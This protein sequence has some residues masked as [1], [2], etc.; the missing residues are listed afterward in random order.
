MKRM[1]DAKLLKYMAI[2]EAVA[3]LS[4]DTSTK[5]GAI[6]LGSEGTEIRSLGYNGSPRGC[7]ADDDGRCETR[8]E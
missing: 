4:K 8:P 1:S 6:I 2:S 5:V 7:S 3:R